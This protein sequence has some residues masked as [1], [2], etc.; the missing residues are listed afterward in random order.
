MTYPNAAFTLL[1]HETQR[2][3]CIRARA[4]LWSITTLFST[5]EFWAWF[6]RRTP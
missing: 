2:R 4:A 3:A 5:P 1:P 6:N